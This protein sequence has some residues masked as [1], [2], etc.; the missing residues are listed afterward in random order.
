[1]DQWLRSRKRMLGG[2]RPVDLLDD[3]DAARVEEA[4]RVSPTAR[5]PDLARPPTGLIDRGGA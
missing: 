4:A 3:G 5:T 1:M 2:G